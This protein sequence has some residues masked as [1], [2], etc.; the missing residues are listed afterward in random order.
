MERSAIATAKMAS[1]TAS[2]IYCAVCKEKMNRYEKEPV[3]L[4]SCGH[5]F[6]RECLIGIN[7]AVGRI[8]C[9]TCRICH[10]GQLP[11]DLP[12]NW[13]LLEML[14][15][16]EGEST[17][18]Q[19]S[20]ELP[21]RNT[22]EAPQSTNH[23]SVDFNES[24]KSNK[25]KESSSNENQNS[26][27]I[28]RSSKFW[29]T[30]GIAAGSVIGG[31]GLVAAAPLALTAVGFTSTGI[32][33]SSFATS[34]MSSAAIANG[35]GVAAGSLV[36]VLQSAGAA[37]ISATATG[38][39]GAAGAGIGGGTA[40]GISKLFGR[41]SSDDSSNCNE[42]DSKSKKNDDGEDSKSKKNE[43]FKDPYEE[44]A[45]LKKKWQK[46][47]KPHMEKTKMMRMIVN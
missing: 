18:N 33:A 28:G 6:C 42:S 29:K 41:A 7:D 26:N 38:A 34:M 40:F 46:I 27:T 19:D 14:D 5:S 31:L 1:N 17:R 2:S 25:D 9:P 44:A 20:T 30:A 11:Q 37:G 24:C 32:A 45:S 15:K 35:G 10:Q 39:L 23:I 8:T 47:V 21:V 22:R 16:E 13:L 43:D 4:P 12:V 3:C 36:A